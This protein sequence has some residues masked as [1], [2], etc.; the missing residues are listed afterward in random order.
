MT[1]VTAIALYSSVKLRRVEPIL[2]SPDSFGQLIHESTKPGTV[3]YVTTVDMCR[4]KTGYIHRW[5]STVVARQAGVSERI[6]AAAHRL[7]AGAVW[8]GPKRGWWGGGGRRF[9]CPRGHGPGDVP[10][11]L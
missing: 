7:P 10:L 4:N 6:V 9:R 2:S 3:Q 11:A 5:V 1:K 8:A